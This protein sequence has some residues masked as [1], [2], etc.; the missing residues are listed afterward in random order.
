MIA[1]KRP[2]YDHFIVL[3]TSR[4]FAHALQEPWTVIISYS[5]WT[6]Y[7]KN[8]NVVFSCICRAPGSSIE[9]FKEWMEEM[10]SK[11]NQKVIFICGDLNI[12][13]LNPNK[14]RMTGEFI[15]TMYSISLHPKI[16][17][18]SR[19][20]SHCATLTD[21]IVTNYMDNNTVSG[22]LINNISDYLPV[23]MTGNARRTRQMKS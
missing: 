23:F 16:T 4:F 13:L 2:S 10:F 18:P 19:I 8:K 5:N 9:L 21:N 15:N 7:R 1:L 3:C 6:I 22:L 12:D 20:T 17:R 11:I 14:H